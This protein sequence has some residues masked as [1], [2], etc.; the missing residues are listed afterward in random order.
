MNRRACTT[1]RFQHELLDIRH[2]LNLLV[3][4]LGRNP[5]RDT[6]YAAEVL[7]SVSYKLE[8][9]EATRPQCREIR[10]ISS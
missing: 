1:P 3:A 5:S 4:R 7:A 10:Q 2:S 8:H 9:W 6:Q